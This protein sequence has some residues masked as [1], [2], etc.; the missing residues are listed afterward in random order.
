MP[1][2]EK[3]IAYPLARPKIKIDYTATLYFRAIKLS[4]KH[5][6][7]TLPC[8]VPSLRGRNEAVGRVGV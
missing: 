4:I 8:T 6:P 3:V 2:Y 7:C 5:C 1:S